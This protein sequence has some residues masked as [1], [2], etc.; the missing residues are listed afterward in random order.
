MPVGCYYIAPYVEEPA[1]YRRAKRWLV[2]LA[3]REDLEAG[4]ALDS[5]A[6]DP[7]LETWW[8]VIEEAKAR[9]RAREIRA[10]HTV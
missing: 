1:W 9:R 8:D 4:Q 10:R 5:L 6:G 2:I 3:E 7:A